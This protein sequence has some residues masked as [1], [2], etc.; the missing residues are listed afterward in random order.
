M[1]EWLNTSVLVSS[2]LGSL[3]AGGLLLTAKPFWWKWVN[4]EAVSKGIK[5]WF[6]FAVLLF[7][8]IGSV[9]YLNYINRSHI[10]PFHPSLTE[11]EAA[12]ARS[13]CMMKAL[14]A[15]AAIDIYGRDRAAAQYYGAC[16]ASKGFE[17]NNP[18][19]VTP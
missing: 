12:A 10:P 7:L 3:V 19:T 17:W 15:T 8:L 4:N 16:L 9:S 14:E 18:R 1:T 2:V 5:A 11:E 13:E 6:P